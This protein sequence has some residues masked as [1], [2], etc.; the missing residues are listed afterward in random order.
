MLLCTCTFHVNRLDLY[1]FTGC[2][3]HLPKIHIDRNI[4]TSLI[5]L[6]DVIQ[7]HTFQQNS[8]FIWIYEYRGGRKEDVNVYGEKSLYY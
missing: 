1:I 8:I 7:T 3:T 5:S 6:G 4:Y 2:Y